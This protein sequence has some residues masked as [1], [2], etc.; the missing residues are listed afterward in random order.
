MAEGATHVEPQQ[1][2]G[3]D[4]FTLCGKEAPNRN[5]DMKPSVLSPS[6]FSISGFDPV[7]FSY[8]WRPSWATL[9]FC[10]RHCA[11][12]RINEPI[13]KDRNK[14]QMMNVVCQCWRASDFGAIQWGSG[15][16]MLAGGR[17]HP[18]PPPSEPL[19]LQLA[20]HWTTETLR[21]HSPTHRAHMHLYMTFH[22]D[23]LLLLSRSFS[24]VIGPLTGAK[25]FASV[26]F[27]HR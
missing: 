18:P 21:T 4:I 19:N 24:F 9:Q 27:E 2:K 25:A 23:G 15:C 26:A 16:R 6:I 22:A 10:Q 5:T 8:A 3:I 17:V 1:F 14:S 12:T 11:P 20:A 7:P 13:N